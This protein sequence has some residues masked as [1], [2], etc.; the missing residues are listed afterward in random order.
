MRITLII[1]LCTFF[2]LAYSQKLDIL[3]SGGSSNKNRKKTTTTINSKSVPNSYWKVYKNYVH[4]PGNAAI[5]TLTKHSGSAAL[6][7]SR[8]I[9]KKKNADVARFVLNTP[10]QAD[11]T[12]AVRFRYAIRE[13]MP[14]NKFWDVAVEEFRFSNK[15]GAYHL[16]TRPANTVKWGTLD[17]PGFTLS[18][19]GFVGIGNGNPLTK[20][21]I[22]KGDVYIDNPNA[23]IVMRSND[24]TCWRITVNKKG[25]LKSKKVECPSAS[26]K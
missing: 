25:K 23:G 4:Y 20:L 12:D 21:H 17:V 1:I 18:N 16:Y 5:G 22:S 19:K 6:Y 14:P 7:V 26:G 10:G 3:G 2:T 24:N 15:G 11:N 8:N 9:K 13:Q